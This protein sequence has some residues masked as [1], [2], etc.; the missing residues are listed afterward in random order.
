MITEFLFCIVSYLKVMNFL[1]GN[2]ELYNEL[3][4]GLSIASYVNMEEDEVEKQ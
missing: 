3:I 4:G 2:L 1:G